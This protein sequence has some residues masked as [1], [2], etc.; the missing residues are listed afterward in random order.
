MPM[1]AVYRLSFD[2]IDGL[3]D[4]HGPGLSGP[5]VYGATEAQRRGS[6]SRR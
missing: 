2:G 4:I 6:T 3:P 1:L 5:T